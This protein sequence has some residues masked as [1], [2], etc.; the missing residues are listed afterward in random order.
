M[1]LCAREF[2]LELFLTSGY[3]SRNIRSAYA[4]II[5]SVCN[6]DLPAFRI[7]YFNIAVTVYLDQ[8]SF[9]I[10]HISLSLHFD[11]PVIKIFNPSGYA[12]RLCYSGRSVPEAYSLY[13][14]VKNIVNT[15]FIHNFAHSSVILLLIHI[16][17]AF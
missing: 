1:S 6:R 15:T 16:H 17:E 4:K 5:F 13:I 7:C 12:K 3:C 10:L 9:K 11:C 14:S 8:H 2:F